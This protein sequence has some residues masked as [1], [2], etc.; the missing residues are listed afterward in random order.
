MSTHQCSEDHHIITHALIDLLDQKSWDSNNII[1]YDPI[2]VTYNHTHRLHEYHQLAKALAIFPW[3]YDDPI[4][5]INVMQPTSSNIDGEVLFSLSPDTSGALWGRWRP[6]LHHQLDTSKKPWSNRFLQ[7]AILGCREEWQRLSVRGRTLFITM[8][9]S[10]G[11]IVVWHLVGNMA[12]WSLMG[13]SYSFFKLKLSKKFMNK[14][15]T[16]VIPAESNNSP[17]MPELSGTVK[18]HAHEM[19][20]EIMG[21]SLQS[22]LSQHLEKLPPGCIW[23][24]KVCKSQN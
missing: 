20:W 22:L 21:N 13:H 7:S 17:G 12:Y 5:H 15:V 11:S 10:L 6:C 8:L 24:H 9:E 23:Q 4:V 14:Q 16:C 19:H 3:A 2:I 1:N 18:G